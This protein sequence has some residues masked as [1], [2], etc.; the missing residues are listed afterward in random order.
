MEEDVKNIINELLSD[1]KSEEVKATYTL[2]NNFDL[3][4]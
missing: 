3:K 1:Y 2:I 4:N